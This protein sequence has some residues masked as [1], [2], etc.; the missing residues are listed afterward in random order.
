MRA[1]PPGDEAAR[2]AFPALL[3]Q[4]RRHRI[5]KA[6]LHVDD[7]AVLV[8]GQDLDLAPEDGVHIDFT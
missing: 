4:E 1:P 6:L 3:L 5:G 7:R 2:L 8:E